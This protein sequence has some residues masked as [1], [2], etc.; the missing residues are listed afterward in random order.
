[1][2]VSVVSRWKPTKVDE[3]IK[4]AKQAKVYWEKH[5]ANPTRPAGSIPAFGPASG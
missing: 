5:G 2:S 4:I 1:M 3:A